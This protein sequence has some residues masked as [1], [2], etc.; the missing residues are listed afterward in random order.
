[1]DEKVGEFPKVSKR[2]GILVCLFTLNLLIVFDN[3]KLLKA[4][5]DRKQVCDVLLVVEQLF[6]AMLEGDPGG[7]SGARPSL[8]PHPS[9]C[10]TLPSLLI[11][12]RS[13]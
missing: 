4:S 7:T 10:N 5:V 13:S 11:L 3:G 8:G 12:P 2:P 6:L 9:I 1:M